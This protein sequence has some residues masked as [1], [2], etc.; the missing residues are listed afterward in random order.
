MDTPPASVSGYPREAIFISYRR[1]D[2]RGASGRVWD[3]LRIGF[4]RERVFRDV[5]SI[6]AGRWRRKIDQALA[7]SVACVAVIGRRWANATNLPRLQDPTDTVRYELEAALERGEQDTLTVVP[8]LVDEVRLDEIPSKDLP[9]SLRP[10]LSEWNVM[11]ISEAGWDHDTQRLITAI[12]KATGLPVQPDFHEWLSLMNGARRGMAAQTPSAAPQPVAEAAQQLTLDGLLHK[13]AET[14]AAER[15]GL[16]QPFEALAAGNTRLAEEA[17]EEEIKSSEQL[18]CAARDLMA[19]GQRHQAESARNVASLALLRGDLSKAV[20]F[21]SQALALDS[22]LP[23]ANLLLGQALFGRGELG[24]AEQA[25]RDELALAAAAGEAQTEASAQL[26]LADCQQALGR[27]Q[28]ALLHLQQARLLT[29]ALVERSAEDTHSRQALAVVLVKQGDLLLALGRRSEAL[30][31]YNEALRIRE[32]LGRQC[33]HDLRAQRELASSLERIA[34]VQLDRRDASAALPLC[35]RSLA[36]REG[37]LR[38]DPGR[39]PWR[40]DVAI[41]HIQLGEAFQIEGNHEAALESFLQGRSMLEILTNSDGANA[42]WQRE[43]AYVHNR[44]GE[45]LLEL[46]R[47]EEAEQA[48]RDGLALIETLVERDSSNAT[49]QGD[50]AISLDHL[51]EL[52]LLKGDPGAAL[53]LYKRALEIRTALVDLS[54]ESSPWL[55]DLFVSQLTVAEKL[56]ALGQHSSA[57][58]SARLALASADGLLARDPVNPQARFD[59][60]EVACKLEAM[61]SED[62]EADRDERLQLLGSA[63]GIINDLRRAD[64]PIPKERWVPTPAEEC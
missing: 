60:A 42:S 47:L 51:A 50:L 16:R 58:T 59:R 57:I 20:R 11:A 33:P 6:G 7:S 18:I 48:F 27:G 24:G 10:L 9:D 39:L 55:R 19:A 56:A 5:A 63:R 2:A 36:I 29:E 8:L 22:Q 25:F 62:S 37:L 13:V 43:L 32:E 49:W 23:E 1:D 61:L 46:E 12:A 14:H 38:E 17:F 26:G 28:Q 44:I 54:P 45:L 34:E 21:V 15:R 53:L 4:G 31:S 3:W 35:N 30:E 64:W 41:G 40:L 52:S